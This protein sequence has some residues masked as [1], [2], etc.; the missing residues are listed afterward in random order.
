MN[1]GTIRR[2]IV[3]QAKQLLGNRNDPSECPCQIIVRA[4]R[5]IEMILCAVARASSAKLN[6]PELVDMDRFA[7]GILDGA[8]ELTG[9]AVEGVN[10]A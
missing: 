2:G 8:D 5:E 9:D 4:S 1:C 3:P 7:G 6:P 10:C